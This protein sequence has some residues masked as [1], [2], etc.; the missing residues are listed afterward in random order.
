MY[1]N[2]FSSSRIGQHTPPFYAVYSD[3]NISSVSFS[4]NNVDEIKPNEPVK[5]LLSCNN[6]LQCIPPHQNG[7]SFIYFPNE[8]NSGLILLEIEGETLHTYNITSPCVFNDF[9]L[10]PNHDR[11]LLI[12]CRLIEDDDSM[13]FVL[14]NRYGTA[15]NTIIP[16]PGGVSARAVVSP[17]ILGMLGFDDDGIANIVSINTQNKTVIY[18]ALELERKVITSNFP[19]ALAHLTRHRLNN[20]FLLTCK[21][22][23][24][25]LVNISSERPL[26]PVILPTSIAALATNARYSLAITLSGSI[27]NIS[28]Q[29]V[30]SQ[31]VPI[32]TAYMQFNTTVIYE[33]DFGPDDQ[34]VYIATDSGTVFINVGMALNGDEEFMHTV[35]SQLCS[36]CPPVVFLNNNTVL[37]SSSISNQAVLLEI[38]RLSPWPP[39][40]LSPNSTLDK[41]PKWYWFTPS[42]DF[43]PLIDSTQASNEELSDGDIAGIAI[44]CTLAFSLLVGFI[45]V[46]KFCYKRTCKTADTVLQEDKKG[47]GI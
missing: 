27:A 47:L 13:R 20:I 23:R 5:I 7:T 44:G 33:A 21:D 37:I 10:I 25:Y 3:G 6:P 18:E 8:N 34:F 28:V 11:P 30:M 41:Q 12:T 40:Q 45:M 26:N 17:I 31:T 4:S 36:Q 46:V 16:V 43:F 14:T 42:V 38:F 29:E 15:D 39:Q 32:R 19:C 35:P 24:S 2:W 22:D 1:V 9:A